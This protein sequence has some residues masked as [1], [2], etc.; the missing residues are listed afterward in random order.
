MKINCCERQHILQEIGYTDTIIDVRS[1]RVRSLLGLQVHNN[2]ADADG[3]QPALVNGEHSVKRNNDQSKAA[4]ESKCMYFLND[5]IHI[6]IC[7]LFLYSPPDSRIG[8]KKVPASLVEGA[9][10]DSEASVLATLDFLGSDNVV[11]D[12]DENLS[13]EEGMAADDEGEIRQRIQGKKSV[14]ELL[15]EDPE[16]EEALAEFDFLVAES[17]DGAGEARS[18][19]DGPDWGMM[20][21][22]YIILYM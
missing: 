8:N 14:E 6:Y 20:S 22:T 4:S 3:A 19:G 15:D 17:E 13:D 11:D 2:E 12:D 16:T 21:L 18:H 7:H 9:L 5:T 1:A 10:L